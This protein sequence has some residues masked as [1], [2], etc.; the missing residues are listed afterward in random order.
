M[1]ENINSLYETVYIDPNIV[2]KGDLT[3]LN[4]YF[5]RVVTLLKKHV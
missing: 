2:R 4:D 5:S 1:E 3:R